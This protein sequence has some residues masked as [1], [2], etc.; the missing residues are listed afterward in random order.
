MN[1]IQK[2]S[3]PTDLLNLRLN[4]GMTLSQKKRLK[5]WLFEHKAHYS[6]A[7]LIKK[8]KR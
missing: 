5:Y 3:D 6:S 2:K 1:D 8:S 4:L 7:F